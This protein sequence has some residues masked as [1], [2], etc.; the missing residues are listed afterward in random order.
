MPAREE[1]DQKYLN[2]A[3]QLETE[4]FDIVNEGFPSQHRVLKTGKSIDAFNQRHGDIWKAHEAELIA[5]G[6]MEAPTP[7]EPVRDLAQ[8]IDELKQKIE[9]LEQL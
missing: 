9:K 5:E 6:L 3:N 7:P 4:F 2:Q 8:E 1:I